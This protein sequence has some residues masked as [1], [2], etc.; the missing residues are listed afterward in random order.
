MKKASFFDWDGTLT[1][2]NKGFLMID[3]SKHL[4]SRNI[5]P[6]E[7]YSKMEESKN[8]YF[9]GKLNYREAIG[10]IPRIYSTTLKGVSENDIKK[11]AEIFA[12]K[13]VE[14]YL[15]PYAK[16]LVTLM[17]KYGMIIGISGAPKELVASLGRRLNFDLSYGSEVE[18]ENEIYTGV[19][20][21][22]LVIKEIKEAILENIVKENK[23]D[24]SKSFGF[25]D[26][27]QDSSF[28]S[29][30]GFP[31]ILNP[32]SKLLD[33]AKQNDWPIFTSKDDVA[34]N[35]KKLFFTSKIMEL[36]ANCV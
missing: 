36:K 31:I 17:S 27:E 5:F 22:N 30:V 4:A 19:L 35:V 10:R 33:I 21:Q 14:E 25:G 26:T 6:K 2:V 12:D 7:S 28:L 15:H 32:N 29:K 16:D 24:L 20:K 34:V 13:V 8:L 1:N 9:E 23:I 3:F 18:I 11:E